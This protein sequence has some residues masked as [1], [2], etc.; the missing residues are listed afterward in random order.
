MTSSQVIVDLE[1]LTNTCFVVMPFDALFEVQYD[2][3]IRPAIEQTG[4]KCVRGDEIY[5]HPSVIHD[6]WHSLRKARLVVAE[7]SGR[8]PNVMY[9]VGLAHAIGKPVVLLTRNKNDVPFDVGALRY[10]YY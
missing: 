4:L 5:S 8:N 3:V 9:E 1:E 7:L 10:L 2:R 6:I